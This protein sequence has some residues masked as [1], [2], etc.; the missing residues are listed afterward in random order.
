M[1]APS[2][3]VPGV[4]DDPEIPARQLDEHDGDVGGDGLE[5]RRGELARQQIRQHRRIDQPSNER[6]VGIG[7]RADVFAGA[8]LFARRH[9]LLHFLEIALCAERI[10]D[11][12]RLL[13]MPL[14]GRARA[15]A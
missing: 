3:S 10:E 14:R 13:K 7:G 2:A 4:R 9:R 6:I 8:D 11:L 1:R 15:G 12:G 5:Q